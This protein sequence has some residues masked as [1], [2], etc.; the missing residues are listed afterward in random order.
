MLGEDGV[1]GRSVEDVSCNGYGSPGTGGGEEHLGHH[2]KKAGPRWGTPRASPQPP[3][4][5]RAPQVGT[6][7]PEVW[8]RTVGWSDRSF[9]SRLVLCLS[10]GR[11]DINNLEAISVLVF[12]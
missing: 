10:T 1:V 12:P 7:H 4:A 11:G 8:V 6:S 2:P 3:S 9:L 5:L